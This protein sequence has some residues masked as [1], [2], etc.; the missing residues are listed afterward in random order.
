MLVESYKDVLNTKIEEH[1]GLRALCIEIVR[2]P[3]FL[4]KVPDERKNKDPGKEKKFKSIAKTHMELKQDIS[5]TIKSCKDSKPGGQLVV[6]ALAKRQIPAYSAFKDVAD[7]SSDLHSLCIA[8]KKARKDD[9]SLLEQYMS[10]VAMKIS[11][12]LGGTNHTAADDSNDTGR[13]NQ[14]LQLAPP[15]RPIMLMGADVSYSK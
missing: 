2:L 4:K 3:S 12:K 8:R 14:T 10:N 7:R 9:A 15:K 11:L 13:I 6:L 1:I 5:N